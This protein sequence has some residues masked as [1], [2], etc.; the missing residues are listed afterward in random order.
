MGRL[1]GPYSP[2]FPEGTLVRVRHSDALRKFKSEWKL[3]HPLA[4]EQLKFAGATAPVISVSF[5]HGADELYELEGVP[6]IWHE[7]CLT[8]AD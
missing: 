1:N 6:G 5:Y 8:P 2:D 7:S 3:H 4:D